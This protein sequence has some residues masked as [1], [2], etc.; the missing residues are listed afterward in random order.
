MVHTENVV[1]RLVEIRV[2]ARPTPE[3]MEKDK[4]YLAGIRARHP[5]HKLRLVADL[6]QGSLLPPGL[7][8]KFVDQLRKESAL[9]ERA[10]MLLAPGS[11]T[12]GLQMERVMREAD[13]SAHHRV[14][15]DRAQLA[16]WM[17]PVLTDEEFA[18]LHVFFQR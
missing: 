3:Q 2:L 18:R 7:A 9:V 15:A 10:A 8:E 12:L 11:N 17:R 1:G 5:G 13:A 6:T 16:A 4:D 14:F